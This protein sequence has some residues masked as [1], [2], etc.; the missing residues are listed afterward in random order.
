MNG[1]TRTRRRHSLAELSQLTDHAT[2]RMLDYW[3]RTG[4]INLGDPPGTG[5]WRQ[6]T[7][8]EACAVLDVVAENQALHERAEH[9]R[10]GDYFRERVA[11]HAEHPSDPW[12]SFIG[13]PEPDQ[14]FDDGEKPA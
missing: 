8:A 13:A 1:R 12:S 11:W 9:V 10:S 4:R 2:Y 3:A 7:A 5:N 6:M 14:E